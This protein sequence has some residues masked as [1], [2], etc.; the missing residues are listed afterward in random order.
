MAA[1]R[2]SG[3]RANALGGRELV[4][5]A[6]A[7]SR[8]P[9]EVVWDLLADLRTHRE[10]GGERQKD[11]TRLLS[12]EAPEGPAKAGTEFRTQGRDPMGTFT[13]RS[14]VTEAT[15]PSAFEF[16]TEA[17]LETKKGK[18]TDWTVVHR[19]EV[20]PA[21][22]GSRIAYTVRIARISELIGALTLFKVPGLRSLGMKASAG[23]GKRGVTNLARLA[24]ERA[25]PRG[26]EER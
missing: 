23:V 22:I 20:S 9:A 25:M 18:T 11:T 1:R 12:L 16:V 6:E 7:T 4:A 10:W 19:Y 21:D 26:K 5:T 3:P 17:H 14:V 8:A 2:T 24:E 15:R 13:D